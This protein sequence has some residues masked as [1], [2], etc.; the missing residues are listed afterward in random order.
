L[1]LVA[2]RLTVQNVESRCDQLRPDIQKP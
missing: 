2:G 1:N